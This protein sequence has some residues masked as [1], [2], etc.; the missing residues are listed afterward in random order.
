MNEHVCNLLIPYNTYKKIDEVLAFHLENEITR[1]A[2]FYL[3]KKR[4]T[5]AVLELESI[6][7]IILQ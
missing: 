5:R 6:A 1:M 3:Q 4:L 2:R 7:Q